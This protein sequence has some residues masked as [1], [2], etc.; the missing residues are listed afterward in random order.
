VNNT[1]VLGGYRNHDLVAFHTSALTLNLV[2]SYKK[3]KKNIESLFLFIVLF[4]GTVPTWWSY[5]LI[6]C[7]NLLL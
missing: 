1:I 2:S 5:V 7:L 4:N 3:R 6:W